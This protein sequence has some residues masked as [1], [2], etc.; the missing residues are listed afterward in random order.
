MTMH[1]GDTAVFSFPDGIK[2]ID[3]VVNAEYTFLEKWP[4][5]GELSVNIAKTQDMIISSAQKLGQIDKTSETTPCFPVD[6]ND[7]DIV[8]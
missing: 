8:N 5:S 3:I 4:Q 6:G 7:I 2:G 1:A